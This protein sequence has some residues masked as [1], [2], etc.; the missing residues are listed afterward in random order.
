MRDKDQKEKMPVYV[1][2]IIFVSAFI[3]VL[4]IAMILTIGQ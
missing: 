3:V 2:V 4:A 1:H